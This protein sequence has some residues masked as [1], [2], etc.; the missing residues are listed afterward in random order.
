M[1]GTGKTHEET[2]AS[3]SIPVL[4]DFMK[5]HKGSIAFDHESINKKTLM[6]KQK[7]IINKYMSKFFNSDEQKVNLSNP[8]ILFYIIEVYIHNALSHIYFSASVARTNMFHSHYTLKQRIY[9]GPTSTDHQLAFLMANQA[10]IK[11]GD[12]VYD[13]FM[14]T[15]SILVACAHFGA[16]CVGS[17]LDIRV[18]RGDGVGTINKAM[19]DDYT[20]GNVHTNFD[21]YKLPHPEVFRMDATF[22]CLQPCELFDAILCDPPYGIRAMARKVG[23]R[24][25]KDQ[26]MLTEEVKMDRISP[27]IQNDNVYGDLLL[28]TLPLLKKQGRLVI[29]FPTC[30]KTE[31]EKVLMPEQKGYKLVSHCINPLPG[32]MLRHMLC[33]EKL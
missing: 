10:Q 2:I 25:K 16:F 14:G 33:Y 7:E 6:E 13:P 26:P 17:D 21:M 20:A 24:S 27:T 23:Q 18:I 29:L 9:I 15:A 28:N 1:L 30:D 12:I 8:D 19:K 32:K 5:L 11:E 4:T 3:A 22:P 31:K